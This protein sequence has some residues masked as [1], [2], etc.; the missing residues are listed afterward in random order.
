MK[1]LFT[2]LLLFALNTIKAQTK[3]YD[4]FI[5]Q[6]DSL[7]KLKQF[8]SSGSAFSD[9]FTS[10]GG[11]GRIDHRISAARS[12]A[13]AKVP[14]SAYVNLEKILSKGYNKDYDQW[15]DDPAFTPLYSD[16]RWHMLVAKLK[17]MKEQSEK[18]LNRPLANQLDSILAADQYFRVRLDSLNKNFGPK[19]KQMQSN[20]VLM[21]EA[22]LLNIV[23]VKAILD[24]YGW[25]GSEIVGTSGS[26]ALF[27]VIQHA[28]LEDQLHYLPMLQQA[29]KNG[30]A[31]GS[32]L[33]LLEDRIALR[34]GGLQ[35]YGSQIGKNEK[36]GRAYVMPLEDPDNVDKRRATVGLQPMSQYVKQWAIEWS[37]DQY[38]KDILSNN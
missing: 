4:Y 35:K 1:Y 29:V 30:K 38:K 12:W 37:V 22:D 19:S 9:A 8:R 28:D 14:D 23:K 3:G 25:L 33:A 10:N 21:Q 26:T 17:S 31:S 7:Y 13:Q 27:L 6:A 24:K 11:L 34:K 2:L 36:T 16:K 15:K 5:I 20:L 18:F 32:E